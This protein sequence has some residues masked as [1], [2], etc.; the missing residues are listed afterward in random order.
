MR[1]F[2]RNL[3]ETLEMMEN[4]EEEIVGK[5]RKPK[6]REKAFETDDADDEEEEATNNL[7]KENNPDTPDSEVYYDGDDSTPWRAPQGPR[8]TSSPTEEAE[9]LITRSNMATSEAPSPSSDEDQYY[10]ISDQQ[11]LELSESLTKLWEDQD[12]KPNGARTP[13]SPAEVDLQG[14][15]AFLSTGITSKPLF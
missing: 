9:R 12:S 3:R 1:K 11:M 5:Y 6:G 7:E 14:R 4:S 10:D 2:R 13:I 8:S 15:S